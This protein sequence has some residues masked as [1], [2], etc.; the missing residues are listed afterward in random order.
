MT[1][2]KLSDNVIHTALFYYVYVHTALFYYMYVH[3]ALF[4]YVYLCLL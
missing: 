1:I 4:Y 2:R 3:T